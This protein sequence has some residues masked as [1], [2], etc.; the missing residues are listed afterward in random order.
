MPPRPVVNAPK[1]AGSSSLICTCKKKVFLNTSRQ[2]LNQYMSVTTTQSHSL[3]NSPP[4][5]VAHTAD[6]PAMPSRLP[7]LFASLAVTV[8]ATLWHRAMISQNQLASAR[9]IQAFQVSE[10]ILCA[11]RATNTPW[12]FLFT[13]NSSG[14]VLYDLLVDCLASPSPKDQSTIDCWTSSCNGEEPIFT[15]NSDV[16][17][18]H[19]T[20]YNSS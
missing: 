8:A 17:F 19:L 1:G 10:E 4:F 11:I 12:S 15:G 6:T 9:R 5:C 7:L 20:L 16:S 18:G 13:H 3:Q 14:C 2:D